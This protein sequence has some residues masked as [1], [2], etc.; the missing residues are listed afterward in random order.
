MSTWVWLGQY[1]KFMPSIARHLWITLLEHVGWP[2]VQ[3]I[4]RGGNL[5]NGVVQFTGVIDGGS[6]THIWILTWIFVLGD[7]ALRP[8]SKSPDQCSQFSCRCT[9]GGGSLE[10]DQAD[11]RQSGEYRHASFQSLLSFYFDQRKGRATKQLLLS[12][13]FLTMVIISR[14]GVSLL[15]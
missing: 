14:S 2:M 12:R 4:C 5:R 15:G 6:N 11:N 8:S 1:S 7:E 10:A 9:H 3:S 13:E